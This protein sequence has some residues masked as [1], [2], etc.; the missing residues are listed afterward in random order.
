MERLFV[1]VPKKSQFKGI[2]VFVDV[3]QDWKAGFSRR[4]L[5]GRTG[6]VEK[7]PKV[8]AAMAEGKLV[9]NEQA[10]QIY[11]FHSNSGFPNKEIM[12]RIQDKKQKPDEYYR[13]LANHN[14]TVTMENGKKGIYIPG[15]VYS[16]KNS[17]IA[18]TVKSTGRAVILNSKAAQL[19]EKLDHYQLAREQFHALIRDL[20]PPYLIKFKFF[21]GTRGKFD[22][23]NMVQIVCDMMV[24]W[25]WVEDDN[26][27]VMLTI[28][29]IK[30][31]WEK[32]KENPG[33]LISIIDPSELQECQNYTA[34]LA[35]SGPVE[36][37]LEGNLID[38]LKDSK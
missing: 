17:K 5:P 31:P 2:R 4:I 9:H 6:I 36:I 22:F 16:S 32:R 30:C 3:D 29:D 11:R 8:I 26:S 12:L 21:R 7:T 24:T 33:V 25:D 27:D 13:S 15:E 34:K 18:T 35:F 37:K 19:Y 20:S 38:G 1:T 14:Y 28:P 10:V 23:H